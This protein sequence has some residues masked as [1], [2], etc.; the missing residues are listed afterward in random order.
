LI[1]EAVTMGLVAIGIL[2][3]P[4][5]FYD[6]FPAGSSSWV[7]PLPPFNEH[8]LRDFGSAGLGLTVLAATAA[9]WMERRVVQAAAIAI[10][11]GS[12]PHT[13]YHFTTTGSYS[14]GDNVASLSGLVVQT[15]VPLVVLYLAREP[16]PGQ[17]PT[18]KEA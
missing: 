16:A 5:G 11:A 15:L 18:P 10:L 14:T 6:N 9:L 12:L 17:S 2:I 1:Y 3:D 4:R 8:L 13:I 7:S